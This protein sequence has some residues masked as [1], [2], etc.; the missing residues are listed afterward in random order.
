MALCSLSI[1]SSAAP[2][3]C[4]GPRDQVAGHDQRLFVGQRDGLA[5]F[6]RGDGRTET[7]RATGGDDQ[8]IDVW[9]GGDVEQRVGTVE[10]R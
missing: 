6:E 1:G 9:V 5:C 7:D 8:Q 10:A 3:R 4:G 2:G